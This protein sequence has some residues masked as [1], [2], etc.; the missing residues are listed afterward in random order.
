[1]KLEITLQDFTPVSVSFDSGA[2][3]L[4]LT[5]LDNLTQGTYNVWLKDAG[6]VVAKYS[7]ILNDGIIE[8]IYIEETIEFNIVEENI[9][10]EL[11]ECS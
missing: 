6:D 8:T 1:M 7:V 3:Y 5:A 10:F 11:N 9:I 2:N 4:P